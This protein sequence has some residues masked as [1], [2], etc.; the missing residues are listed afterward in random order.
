MF[1]HLKQSWLSAVI[2]VLL[3]ISQISLAGCG[4]HPT[5][6]SPA[7]AAPAGP[8][9]HITVSAVG[10]LLMHNTVVFSAYDDTTG[11]YDFR[12][13]FAPVAPYLKMT[14]YSVANL[15]TRLAGPQF[16]YSGYP[17]FNTPAELAANMRDV[18]I[19]LMATANNHS[20]D[21]GWP[22]IVNTLDNLDAAGLAHIGTYRSP[23]EQANPFIV[24]VKGIKLAWLN[25]TAVN[26][27]LSLPPDK[28]FALNLWDPQEATAG[29]EK[30]RQHGADLVIVVMHFGTEYQR[31]PNDTQ[32]QIARQLAVAGADVIIGSHPHVVQPIEVLTARRAD[33][34]LH[35]CLVAY[36][37]GNFISDQ[38]WRYS[39]CGIILYLDIIKDN[40][41]ARLEKVS[42]LPVWVQ[43][44]EAG[45]TI[46]FRVLPVLSAAAVLNDGSLSAAE[47]NLM[48]QAWTDTTS[49]L[50]DPAHGILPYQKRES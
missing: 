46:S 28:S 44:R 43:K 42:Y 35:Q 24:D 48:I 20:L 7:P 6:A 22:G 29:I 41:G 21:M 38:P 33:G 8:A 34:K 3:S 1:G 36:S 30:A 11:T 5:P 17:L 10:D 14:D 26:N 50:N 18:G 49:Y 47:K 16:G 40:N 25:Y 31:I 37:L 13:Q 2:I 4:Q 12:P 32:Q 19:R 45:G 27:G 15:E 9:V 23:A 39:D